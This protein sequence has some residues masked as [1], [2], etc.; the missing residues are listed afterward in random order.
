[1]NSYIYACFAAA[2]HAKI[3]GDIQFSSLGKFQLEN[4]SF[5][6][7]AK[8]IDFES[9][10]EPFLFATSFSRDPDVPGSV[11]VVPDLKKAVTAGDVSTLKATKLN[12]GNSIRYPNDASMAPPTAFEA[13]RVIAV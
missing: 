1:M 5:V 10:S 11:T 6:H 9:T 3:V 13:N 4:P 7:V 12:V 8:W 2:I